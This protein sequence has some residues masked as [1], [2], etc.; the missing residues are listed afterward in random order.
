M[1]VTLCSD[2][3]IQELNKEDRECNEPTDILSY[4]FVQFDKPGQIPSDMEWAYLGEIYVSMSTVM[5]FTEKN[6]N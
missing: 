1:E 6:S 4:P 3:F 2:S 5:Q